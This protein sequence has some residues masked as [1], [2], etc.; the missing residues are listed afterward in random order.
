MKGTLTTLNRILAKA[1]RELGARG[2]RE[3]ACELAAEAW[4]T[5]RRVD[6]KEAELMN[7]VL[8]QLTSAGHA[9][10]TPDGVPVDVDEGLGSGESDADEIGAERELDVR[11]LPP[12]ARHGLIFATFHGLKPGQGFILVNDHDPKPLYYQFSFEH[13]GGFTWT[14]VESGPET[15]RVRIGK[16]EA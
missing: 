2:A 13:P 3:R 15:W 11:S 6:A 5:L 14:A 1:L 9:G 8:H 4:T 10:K 16:P 12:A 7:S